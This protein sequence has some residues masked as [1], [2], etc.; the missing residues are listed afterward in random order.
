MEQG[1]T[2]PRRTYNHASAPEGV[3]FQAAK[4]GDVARLQAALDDGGSTEEVTSIVCYG[5]ISLFRTRMS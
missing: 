5:W 4:D 2:R 3:V 1:A